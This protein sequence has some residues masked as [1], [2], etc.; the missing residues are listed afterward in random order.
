MT[1]VNKGTAQ[2]GGVYT[3]VTLDGTAYKV[4]TTAGAS[5]AG[6][7][8]AS[9]TIY[10]DANDNIIY[11]T[12]VGSSDYAYLM[13][14][15]A[16]T[17]FT[18]EYQAQL[19]FQ[20]GSVKIVDLAATHKSG[21]GLTSTNDVYTYVV[22]ADG[23]YTL[24]VPATVG[25]VTTV[26]NKVPAVDT[27]KNADMNTTFVVGVVNVGTGV[28]T[29]TSYTG[30]A[31][32]PTFTANGTEKI[33]YAM[34]P[35][36]GTVAAAFCVDSTVAGASTNNVMALYKT[37]VEPRINSGVANTYYSV[38]AVVDGKVTTVKLDTTTYAG[39]SNGFFLAS[40][41]TIDGN[42]N[43]AALT[44]VATSG[45]YQQQYSFSTFGAY[46]NGNITLD[47]AKY[48]DASVPVVVWNKAAKALQITTV[49]AVFAMTA[50][51]TGAYTTELSVGGVA[52]AITGIYMTIDY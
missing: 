2:V 25:Q 11:S 31:S 24:S 38:A 48:V 46:E 39:L 42:G 16:A 19:L 22:G 37:G 49:D 36:T 3:S 18:T 30:I 45:A 6:T 23:K 52:G 47:T 1:G 21:A 10:L 32:V 27:G 4:N 5:Y 15:A 26:T 14:A 9:E 43:Y 8:D 17:S 28:T 35:I 29:Y 12:G 33:N 44:E 13:G 20:D 50:A 7:Y 41:G 34:N 51:T 40:G